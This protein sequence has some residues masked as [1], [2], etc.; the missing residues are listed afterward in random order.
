MK[1][2]LNI[3]LIGRGGRESA[4]VKKMQESPRLAS[5]H[6]LPKQPG[7]SV[8]VDISPLDFDAI[9]AYCRQQAIDLVVVGPEAPIVAGIADFLEERG[10]PT[11]APSRLCGRLEG[12]KEFAKEFMSVNG[13]PSARFMTVTTDTL[14]EGLEFLE[15]QRPPFVV[16]A[17]GLAAGKGVL[18]TEDL[19]EAKFVMREMLDGMF[20]ES[21]S[22][23]VLEE[24]LTGTEVSLFLAVS[25]SE[26][27]V[28]AS[29]RDYKRLHED[30]KGPN[31]TGIGSISPS[32]L[33]DE[34]FVKKVEKSIIRPTLRGLSDLGLDYKGI[35]Y[36]GLMDCSGFP[37]LLEYNVRFGDPETQAIMP[38]LDIDLID[39]FEAVLEGNLPKQIAKREN[40]H[41]VAIVTAENGYPASVATGAEVIIPSDVPDCNVF[42][43]GSVRVLED[44]MLK[45][46]GGRV[47]TAVGIASS[48]G[49]AYERALKGAEMI[50]FDGKYYRTDIG[51]DLDATL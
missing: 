28:I 15:S 10:I 24:F 34:T 8:S 19:N 30:N 50:V 5:L 21:S 43:T 49:E 36:L 9:A 1:E 45:V 33:A 20:D 32:P 35:L 25:G 26:Y 27:S 39:L 6:T 37:M 3:L 18:I 38:R 31:T 48:Y 11:F 23:V 29:A 13:I 40:C 16:K 44:G 7:G 12:S 4:L 22:T 14:E 17:D 2:K 47:A 51:K 46:G 41:T 42:Y